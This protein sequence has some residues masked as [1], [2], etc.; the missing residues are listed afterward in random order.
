MNYFFCRGL[1]AKDIV[2]EKTLEIMRKRTDWGD[3]LASV[4]LPADMEQPPTGKEVK[5]FNKPMW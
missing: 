5:P 3:L 4:S 1:S 2:P